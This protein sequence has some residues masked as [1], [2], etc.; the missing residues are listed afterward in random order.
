[1][2]NI[3][4]IH[5]G[6][7]AVYHLDSLDSAELDQWVAIIMQTTREWDKSKTYCSLHDFRDFNLLTPDLRRASERANAFTA[8]LNMGKAYSAVVANPSALAMVGKT[9]VEW[10][11]RYSNK[12]TIRRM[13]FDMD[14]AI[15]WLIEVGK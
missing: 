2:A 14:K 11:L 3:E 4:F 7:I 6:K 13:F 10:K 8:T 9:F 5:D 15:Q 1:M 12:D